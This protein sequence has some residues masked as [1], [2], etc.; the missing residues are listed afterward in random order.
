MQC[1]PL[2]LVFP[3]FGPRSVSHS[4]SR[5]GFR[6]VSRP[7]SRFGSRSVSRSV[8]RFG[9]RSVSR[10]VSSFGFRSVSRSVSHIGFRSTIL[11]SRPTP[12]PVPVPD[13]VSVSPSSQ[14][15]LPLLLALL[16][17][18]VA[19]YRTQR[20]I[21]DSHSARPRRV[22]SCGSRPRPVT[23]N[24]SSRQRQEKRRREGIPHQTARQI[25]APAPPQE[26]IRA[27]IHLTI[28]SEDFGSSASATASEVEAAEHR[29][30]K[31][32]VS[33]SKRLNTTF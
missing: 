13:S 2:L 10:S 14:Q 31:R 12:V 28:D 23:S 7:V 29:T 26:P 8:S 24:T 11:D 22:R 16:P 17:R 6:F 5:F 25:P 9:F 19:L 15:R 32:V 21:T 1:F 30:P 3:R 20:L 27:N 18:G 33:L 4:V